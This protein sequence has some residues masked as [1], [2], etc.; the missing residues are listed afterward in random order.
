MKLKVG[1]NILVISGKNRGKSGKIRRILKKENQVIVEKINMIT[2]HIKKTRAR[3]G[4][5]IRYEA[6][7][8]AS[9][10]MLL[11]LD[12]SGPSRIGYKI[13]EPGEKV[14]REKV[15]ILKRNNQMLTEKTKP[16]KS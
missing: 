7:I 5:I 14:R 16:T 6:P 10:V 3:P 15:R 1:D 13:L 8:H 9:N 11:C 2:K 12:G 4:E